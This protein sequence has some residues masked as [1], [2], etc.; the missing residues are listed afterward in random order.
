MPVLLSGRNEII[1][2]MQQLVPSG[3]P[4][5]QDPLTLHE[6]VSLTQAL[7]TEYQ[8]LG[9]LQADPFDEAWTRSLHLYEQEVRNL[10]E[11]KSVLVTGGEGFVGSRLIR[12]LL[13]LGVEKVS[14]I[15]N[16][17][18]KTGLDEL[19]LKHA[20]KVKLYP[21]DVRDLDAVRQVFAEERPTIV[22][23]LAA[24]RIPGVAEK[25]IRET[26][27]TN[28]FGTQ[29]IIQVCEEYSVQQC[30]FSSTGKS[31][32]YWTGEVYAAT[33]KICEWL[34]AHAAQHS[35]V[36][37]GMVRFTHMLDNSSMGEQISHKIQVNRPVNIHAPDRYVVGQNVGE[38]I[39]LLLNAL[40]HTR[41][42]RLRFVLVRNLGWP[43]ESLEFALYKIQQSGKN[44]PIYF[45]G[46]PPGYEEPFFLGQV[47][48]DNQPEIN[49][50]VNVLETKNF[51]EVSTSGD[52]IISEV[53]P[54]ESSILKTHLAQLSSI[55]NTCAASPVEIKQYIGEFVKDVALST[56]NQAP[57]SR[58]LQIL[59]WGIDLKQYERQEFCLSAYQ[60]F[61]ELVIRSLC[62]RF[63]CTTLEQYH[64]PPQKFERLLAVLESLPSLQTEI[65][66]MRSLLYPRDAV[67]VCQTIKQLAQGHN[68]VTEVNPSSTESPRWSG[69]SPHSV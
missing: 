62:P 19:C 28:I 2:R 14:S 10:L 25:K 33:K 32:R 45:E 60:P 59:N 4:E 38:A 55:C 43:V 50:L 35:S 47:D 12:K 58:I 40:F 53:V 64:F 63:N 20:G 13:E 48:W 42:S 15:D 56:F 17:R 61:I 44:L 16:N 37:Y 69:A 57:V 21:V 1:A 31:S 9:R 52:L 27:T 49:T 3:T 34:F 54:F 26:V 46:I 68:K 51:F 8:V 30:I 23:H 18:Q 7:I 41:S 29:N 36:Q 22:F 65:A 39:H 6:L 11:G 5:P 66:F 67:N 24:I